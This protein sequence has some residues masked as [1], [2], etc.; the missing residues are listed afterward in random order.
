MIGLKMNNNE[1]V[2]LI[3][4]DKSSGEITE[5]EI[6]TILGTQMTGQFK[7]SCGKD[8]LVEL[9]NLFKA[10]F[11]ALGIFTPIIFN[12]SP[13]SSYYRVVKKVKIPS[14]G[15][16]KRVE[17]ADFRNCKILTTYSVPNVGSL[18]QL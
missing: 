3:V 10:I 7:F 17:N 13:A 16:S 2:D 8:H 14:K 4:G 1:M 18:V 12:I 9:S 15:P 6:G 11:Q 5:V